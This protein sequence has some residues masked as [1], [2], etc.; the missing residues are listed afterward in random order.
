MTFVTGNAM[1]NQEGTPHVAFTCGNIDVTYPKPVDCTA[2]G[3]VVTAQATFPDCWDGTTTFDV[4]AGIGMSHFYYSTNG[5]CPPGTVPCPTGNE[6]PGKLMA[7][8]V[9]QETFIDP[10]TN[11]PMVNPNNADGTLGLSF[12]SGPYFTYHADF[13][14]SWNHIIQE[15]TDKCLNHTPCPSSVT[16][17]PIQ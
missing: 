4:P 5:V 14:N 1:A 17:I 13:L 8:L 10:R 16:G 11:A 3:G 15:I 12:S 9:T 6:P 2:S 7:Q